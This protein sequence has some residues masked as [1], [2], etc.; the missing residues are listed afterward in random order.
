MTTYG[1]IDLGQSWLSQCWLIISEVLRHSPES[2]FTRNTDEEECKFSL[3]RKVEVI[4]NCL[5]FKLFI[6]SPVRPFNDMFQIF[7]RALTYMSA[8]TFSMKFVHRLHFKK[9]LAKSPRGQWVNT[10]NWSAAYLYVSVNYGIIGSN[11]GLSLVRCQAIIGTNAG[12][13]SVGR[14]R[15][16]F[17]EI[18]MDE[19]A[20]ENVVLKLAAILS[21]PQCVKINKTRTPQ[22]VKIKQELS[23]C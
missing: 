17:I 12:L 11:N 7:Q 23:M 22:C 9:I 10:W 4:A 3:R 8:W 6:L 1:N 18:W 13:L 5:F 16:N 19:N 14:L 21:Q 20:F 2:N 15:T